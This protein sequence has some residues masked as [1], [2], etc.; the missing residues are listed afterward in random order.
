MRKTFAGLAASISLATALPVPA[1]HSGAM[2]DTTKTLTLTGT[3][4][5]FQWSSP[6]CWIQLLVPAAAS[7]AS[8]ATEWSVEMASPLQVQMGGWKHG[9][10]KPGDK[11]T[12]VI[13]PMR[14]GTSGGNFVSATT[15]DGRP[16]GQLPQAGAQ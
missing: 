5:E 4:R 13:H 15:A 11:I 10:L 16:L 3:V 7:N 8:P 6:H 12:V 1:H 2:F 14:D 9:T